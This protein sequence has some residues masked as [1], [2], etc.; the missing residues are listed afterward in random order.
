MNP[1]IELQFPI[2]MRARLRHTAGHA[3]TARKYG[4]LTEE[5]HAYNVLLFELGVYAEELGLIED[6]VH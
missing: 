3:E 5:L 6:Q 2:L 1:D 4:D